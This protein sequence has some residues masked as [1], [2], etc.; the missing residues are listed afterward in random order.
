MKL[1]NVSYNVKE[2]NREVDSLVGKAIP[3]IRRFKMRG[4]GSQRF[5]IEA[6]P[7][8]LSELLSQTSSLDFCNIELRQNGILIWYRM[9][10]HNYV[11]AIPYGSLRI[12]VSGRRLL[13]KSGQEGL[14]LFPAHN[15]KLETRFIDK[16]L[17]MKNG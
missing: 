17:K 5:E 8:Q 4:I 10:L 14:S 7:N 2:I 6:A 15:A 1:L 16:M 12:T 11:L 9:K 13:I 3:W